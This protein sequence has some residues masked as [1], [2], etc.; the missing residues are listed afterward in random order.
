VSSG[1]RD[2]AGKELG[3]SPNFA[4]VHYSHGLDRFY[5]TQRVQ[6]QVRPGRAFRCATAD[7]RLA[8]QGEGIR[9]TRRGS[10]LGMPL[11]PGVRL[12]VLAQ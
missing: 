7:G 11:P 12:P 10:H 4:I 8:P 9:P 1:S 5:I 6:G 2:F 3:R